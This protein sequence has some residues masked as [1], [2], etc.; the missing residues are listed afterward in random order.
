MEADRS[1]GEE[2]SSESGVGS[3]L[4]ASRKRVDE[5]LRYV[6]ASLR[7]RYPY[8]EA[9]EEGRYNELPGPTYAVGFVRAYAE[10]LGLDSEEVVRRFKAEAIE[11]KGK[12]D[13]TFP[14]PIPETGIPGGAVA[15]VGVLI[16]ALA[17]GGWYISTSDGNLYDSL[18]SPIPER[19]AELFPG[20]DGPDQIATEESETP[21]SE[22]EPPA[23]LAVEV[24]PQPVATPEV[25]S[26]AIAPADNTSSVESITPLEPTAVVTSEPE[27]TP[28]ATPVETA[29]SAVTESADS[30]VVDSLE[31]V[32]EIA[33]NNQPQE[34]ARVVEAVTESSTPTEPVV[35]IE[36][37]E[38]PVTTPVPAAQ[39]STPES[40][41]VS[42]TSDVENS[43]ESATQT[44]VASTPAVTQSEPASEPEP[45]PE[46]TPTQQTYDIADSDL[47][48]EETSP[49]PVPISVPQNLAMEVEEEALVE[50]QPEPQSE[51][52]SE[53]VVVASQ[54][55]PAVTQPTAVSTGIVI[56]AIADSWV[57]IINSR[58]DSVIMERIMKT[59]DQYQVPE[60][61]N[62]RL[63]AGN[64]G[65]IEL[66][67]DGVVVPSIGPSGAVRRNVQL[68]ASRLRSGTA[69]AN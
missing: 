8:L 4:R 47:V 48:Q 58:D 25:T 54:S 18:I 36:T 41:T 32:A 61:G 7:I 53:P 68:D 55:E 38:Q 15:F 28:P 63:M 46:V 65:G 29:V 2:T 51:P 19:I 37:V 11:N 59:G 34:V 56:K 14:E 44:E 23:I 40:P 9:I 62:L 22:P 3:L 31:V 17:Y 49:A 1:Q 13:L 45:E 21:N 50:P 39:P 12:S 57:Q 24:Q 33:E 27:P 67:V 26:P 30:T 10:H 20:D 64:A 5:D 35:K 66:L 6:A 60:I 43:A 16:A 42:V 69:T 52:E